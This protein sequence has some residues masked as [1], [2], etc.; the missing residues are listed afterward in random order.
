MLAG[1]LGTV[2]LVA[3]LPQSFAQVTLRARLRALPFKI[4]YESYVHSNWDIFVANADG[5]DPV[6]LTATPDENE[7]Y[8]Q[9]SR[10]GRHICFVSDTGEGRHIIRSLY[11]M[12][13]DG[14]HRLK[15][16]DRARQ[17]FWT[18]DGRE[19]G[20]LPQ[21]YPLFRPNDGYTDG[22]VFYDLASGR[23]TAHPN[24][25]NLHELY[26]PSFATN[27]K[28][29]ASTVHGGMGIGHAIILIAAHGTNIIKLDIP[30][31]R[32]CLS[33]N[34]KE[35]AWGASDHELVVASLDL[36]SDHPQV[37]PW[38]FRIKDAKNKVYHVD[39]S[40]DG[41]FLSFSR[42]PEGDGDP[43]RV[44]TYQVPNEMIGAYAPGWNIEVVSADR[45][46]TLDL[47]QASPAEVVQVTTNGCSNKESAW[48]RV[49]ASG[50]R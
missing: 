44:G 18:P 16:A 26:N 39:W 20:Y 6:N 46:G 14:H 21:L 40:P 50:R 28:W 2:L 22:M 5:S 12:D 37:G 17:P 31:C 35:I 4:A 7:H 13:T 24:S 27:G 32:P 45:T 10:D 38:R 43:N 25:A 48:F 1:W 19:I 8:P 11:V 41:R 49:P 23:T 42:G 3:T 34:G 29:I 15:I 36:N 47:N 30:G 9:V 33:P